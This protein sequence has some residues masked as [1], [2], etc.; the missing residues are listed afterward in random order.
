VEPGN[1]G[2]SGARRLGYDLPDDNEYH[3]LQF[4]M[5]PVL[6][7]FALSDFRID[8][9]QGA[10]NIA[11]IDYVRVGTVAPDADS[12]GLPDTVETKTGVY[13]GPRD[14]GSDPARADTDRDGVPDGAEVAF[15]TD[16]ND[17]AQFPSPSIRYLTSDAVYVVGEAIE[18]N[19]PQV[20]NGTAS[21]FSISPV[22]PAG[23]SLDPSTGTISGTPTAAVP[24][25]DYTVTA[26]LVGGQT[27]TATLR[28]ESRSPFLA[29]PVNRYSFRPEQP[30][31]PIV[32]I[33][34]GPAP[35]SYQV[36]PAL[37]E[38]LTFDPA[39]GEVAGTP[40]AYSPA[41][42]YT[43]SAAYNG[44]PN[45]EA[46]LVLSVLEDPVVTVDPTEPL[47][48]YYS[49][50]EYDD[51][52]DADTLGIRNSVAPLTVSDGRLVVQTTGGDP[53]FGKAFAIDHDFR[54][55]EWRMR[56][57]AGSPVP[58]RLY[59]A[60][61]AEGRQNLSE[62]TAFSVVDIN[63]DGADHVYRVDFTRAL[64][65]RF[66]I[67]RLDPGDGA[68]HAMEIDYIRFGGFDAVLSASAQSDGTL[69]L[70]WPVA[71]EGY[72]LQSA[73]S[74]TGPWTPDNAAAQT[75]GS[76]RYVVVQNSDAARF[77]RLAR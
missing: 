76:Q 23:L 29:F 73:A 38:G 52:A 74:V 68:D 1:G 49:Y 3:L 5:T 61:D 19:T 70:A 6:N 59:W 55:M 44:F 25:G 64:E 39:T 20:N 14:T 57:T 72:T 12:D 43:V 27:A 51:P 10:G 63:T 8:P 71:A 7:G 11:E 26:N 75:E 69:R 33:A 66:T 28:I 40:A 67:M 54:I 56:V 31:T 30:I 13:V 16:P 24:P 60:E 65:G 9:G 41:A 21:S 77:Y 42:T 22:L 36:T 37:P 50:G 34:R 17:S 62:L 15:G 53:Y 32:P 35:T 58:L 45:A 2:F 4:D 46:D 47:L 18:A 48:S